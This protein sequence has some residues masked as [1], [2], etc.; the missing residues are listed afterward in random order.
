M[1]VS[2]AVTWLLQHETALCD[3]A[4]KLLCILLL[5][6]STFFRRRQVPGLQLCL[7]LLLS[8]MDDALRFRPTLIFRC[9]C[10]RWIHSH[11]V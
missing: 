7:L 4:S 9:H 5:I 1:P 10:N 11:A 2:P 6:V 3:K 8:R